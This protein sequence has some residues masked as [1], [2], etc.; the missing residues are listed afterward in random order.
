MT[1]NDLAG[2]EDQLSHD[3]GVSTDHLQ[4]EHVETVGWAHDGGNTSL[5]TLS[6]V[7]GLM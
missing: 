4:W 2:L 6:V 5:A 3:L 7:A 1:E